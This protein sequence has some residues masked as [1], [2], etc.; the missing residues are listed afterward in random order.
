MCAPI[1]AEAVHD[2]RDP[3]SF[4]PGPRLSSGHC[5][6]PEMSHHHYICT[7]ANRKGG[8]VGGACRRCAR[9]SC[10]KGCWE[11]KSSPRTPGGATA[12][13]TSTGCLTI[14]Y[15]Q[16]IGCKKIIVLQN[17]HLGGVGKTQQKMSKWLMGNSVREQKW[18]HLFLIDEP[19]PNTCLGGG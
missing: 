6:Y 15:T 5:L 17:W 7:S 8:R 11:I 19:L 3:G 9:G 4:Y 10:C 14:L 16:Y 13:F 12:K 1:W 18:P 2:S